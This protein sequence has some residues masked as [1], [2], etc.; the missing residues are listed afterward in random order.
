MPSVREKGYKL[1]ASTQTKWIQR[2]LFE[3]R[4]RY[5]LVNTVGYQIVRVSHE[6]SMEMKYNLVHA[7]LHHNS[8]GRF[9][10][11]LNVK[12]LGFIFRFTF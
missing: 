10:H 8:F 1:T 2:E 11:V 6:L 7:Q 12:T 4:L 3:L 9:E 5:S